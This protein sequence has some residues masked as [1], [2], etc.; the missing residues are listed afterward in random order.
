MG[1]NS[2]KSLIDLTCGKKHPFTRLYKYILFHEKL[3]NFDKLLAFAFFTIKGD[4]VPSS[5]KLARKFHVHC[6]TVSRSKK[7][8]FRN[9][10]MI[11]HPELEGAQRKVW[12]EEEKKGKK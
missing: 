9:C 11:V 7:Q 2:L 12:E 3:N 8:I 4:R 1:R 6:S 5:A 10:K